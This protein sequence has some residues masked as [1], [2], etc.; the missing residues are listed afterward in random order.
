MSE[1]D[2][3]AKRAEAQL[4]RIK[5]ALAELSEHFDTVQIFATIHDNGELGGTRFFRQGTGCSFARAGFIAHWLEMEREGA[6]IEARRNAK[7]A[8][9]E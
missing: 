2:E 4:A 6:R 3:Q 8:E 5:K 1:S 7:E 9:S